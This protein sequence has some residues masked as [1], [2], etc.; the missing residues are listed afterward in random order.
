MMAYYLP[1]RH[2]RQEPILDASKCA[3]LFIDVQNYNCHRSGAIYKQGDK[4]GGDEDPGVS[5]FFS[6]L[7]AT[8]IPAWVRLRA[9]CRAAGM[10]VMYTVIQSLTSDGRDRGLDY[11]ISGFHVPPGSWDAQ[12]IEQLSPGP[13]EMVLPKT[14]SSVFNST[15]IDF[16]LRSM[17]VR[18]LVLAGCVTDQCVAHAVMDAC[19]LGYLVTLVPDATATYSQQRHDAALAAV[20][21]YCRQR[22]VEELEQELQA[23][24]VDPEQRRQQEQAGKK[25]AAE[26]PAGEAG[27]G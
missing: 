5:Y 18:Q 14:S 9:A 8:C 22:T 17:G 24:A 4:T 3:V 20:G 2:L 13:D 23:L 21:G 15:N 27:D 12:M 6:R 16:I 7:E 10:E 11:V 1:Q 26:G 25:R 19:D